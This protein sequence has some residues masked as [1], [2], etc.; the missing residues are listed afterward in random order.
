MV[1]VSGECL[2][3]I[4]NWKESLQ[5]TNVLPIDSKIKPEFDLVKMGSLKKKETCNSTIES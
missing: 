1:E 3:S 4:E 5:Q 2:R